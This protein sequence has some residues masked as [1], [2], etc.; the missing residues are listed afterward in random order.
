IAKRIT[1]WAHNQL[2]QRIQIPF[3]ADSQPVVVFNPHPWPLSAD[4]ELQYGAKPSGVHVVDEV[5]GQV[6]AQR[7]Q[8][9]ATTDDKGRAAVVF[10]AELPALGYRLYRLVAG[11]APAGLCWSGQR[12]PR[13][14]TASS[15]HLENEFLRV[16]F[17][18]QTG[19]LTSLLD[20]RTGLDPL[21]GATGE[22][23]QIS[24]DPTDT[25]GHRVVS[26]AGLGTPMHLSRIVLREAGVVRGR[27]RV[28][29]EWGRSTL[30]EEFILSSGSDALEVRVTI[31]WHEQAHLLKLRFPLALDNPVATQQIP[32]GFISRPVDAAEVPGQSWVDLTGELADGRRAGLT[33]VNNAK[34]GY[35][36]SPV[37]Q[38]DSGWSPSI[39]ITALRSPV[40]SWHDPRTLDPD[41]LY[42]FQDQGLQYFR[43]LLIPHADYWRDGEPTRRAEELGLS[44]RAQLESFHDGPLPPVDSFLEVSQTGG[45]G[46]VLVT[47]FKG[48]EDGDGDA[49]VRAVEVAGKPGQ[50]VIS[51]PFLGRSLQA[52]FGPQQL[53][54]FLVPA[55]PARPI[56]EVDLV[57]WPIAERARG[58]WHEVGETD[59]GDG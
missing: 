57:E 12:A 48:A 56:S 17:D 6:P 22:H 26:Y 18:P 24:Q 52:D 13:A 58:A 49:V 9:T 14:V 55:D 21:T 3:T 44:P 33:V 16:E 23:T 5:G 34:H 39:G 30:V 7:T 10:R 4:V 59:E 25:W 29:R 41:G 19:W 54:T 53:R 2:A 37:G 36:F 43:C 20:K 31:D 1:N 32:Y 50:V 11:A 51:I 46:K 45:S 47:A 15:T 38:P 28:E 35:D 27:L 42:A 40:Y 8:S